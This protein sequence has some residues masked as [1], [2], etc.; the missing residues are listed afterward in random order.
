MNISKE[1]HNKIKIAIWEDLE[2][3]FA[4]FLWLFNQIRESQR[5]L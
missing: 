4:I 3:L 1:T 5:N 2:L